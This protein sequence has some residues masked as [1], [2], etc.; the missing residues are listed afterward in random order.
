MLDIAARFK[1]D[2]QL[3]DGAIG[4]SDHR[5]SAKLS[6]SFAIANRQL[7]IEMK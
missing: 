2:A 4:Y 7:K 3:A 1:Q 5:S 6:F